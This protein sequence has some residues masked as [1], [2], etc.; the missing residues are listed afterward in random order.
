MSRQAVKTMYD[1]SLLYARSKFDQYYGKKIRVEQW[2][3]IVKICENRGLVSPDGIIEP[4]VLQTLA[5]IKRNCGA[6]KST[7]TIYN[8]YFDLLEA[9]KKNQ[10]IHGFQVWKDVKKLC[11]EH[12]KFEPVNST[13]YGWFQRSGLKYRAESKYSVD[14]IIP[15]YIR[16]MYAKQP[17]T[18]KVSNDKLLA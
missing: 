6:F 10:F 14:E 16:A 17:K 11:L 8:N 15:V 13:V 18:K 12:A 9:L 2:R 7:Q 5:T 3:E 4:S 1:A